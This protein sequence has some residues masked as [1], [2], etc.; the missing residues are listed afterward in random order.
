MHEGISVATAERTRIPHESRSS[1]VSQSVLPPPY[2]PNGNSPVFVAETTTTR[3]EVVTTTTT[4]HFLSLSPWRKRS[5]ANLLHQN[6]DTKVN[7]LREANTFPPSSS[8]ILVE[9]ELPPTPPHDQQAD[10]DIAQTSSASTDQ[11]LADESSTE[12]SASPPADPG[13]SPNR[14]PPSGIQSTGVLARAP[15]GLEFPH[16]LP[17]TRT[18]SSAN[19]SVSSAISPVA[20]HDVNVS[21][22]HRNESISPNSKREG[23]VPIDVTYDENRRRRSRSVSFGASFL[24]FGSAN[25]KGKSKEEETNSQSSVKV[26]PKTISRKPSFWSRKK[27]ENIVLSSATSDSAKDHFTPLLPLP[28][29]SPFDANI[30][31]NPPSPHHY[32]N[33]QRSFERGNQTAE[34]IGFR[35]P[36]TAN[37][38]YGRHPSRFTTVE[39][40]GTP[41][42][43]TCSSRKSQK[44]TTSQRP[45]SLTNP[46]ESSLSPLDQSISAEPPLRSGSSSSS[47]DTRSRPNSSTSSGYSLDNGLKIFSSGD[48]QGSGKSQTP[49]RTKSQSNLPVPLKD[50]ESPE[51]YLDRLKA[52][53][54]KVEIAGILASRCVVSDN[55]FLVCLLSYDPIALTLSTSKLSGHTL[56]NL[57][58][59]TTPLM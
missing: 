38:S 2:D 10:S 36:A 47:Q 51:L 31:I 18:P 35:R 58:S 24:R 41:D 12:Y 26:S 8:A 13:N 48:T 50:E 57:I 20:K 17:H 11:G 33:T 4:T 30:T 37:P 14:G 55:A 28:P 46:H 27:P 16:A 7:G 21:E 53:V 25:I 43:F 19:V 29:I 22:S 45:H 1:D 40:L 23:P 39:P 59:S 56:D 49:P 54:S 32:R 5:F 34:T 3:T 9:K 6:T 52:A 42:V 15:L 44:P